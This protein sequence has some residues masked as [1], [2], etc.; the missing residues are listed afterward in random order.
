MATKVVFLVIDGY[1]QV[2]AAK[3]RILTIVFYFDF[4]NCIVRTDFLFVNFFFSMMSSGAKMDERERYKRA[5][6]ELLLLAHGWSI[7]S[8]SRGAAH[9]LIENAL[10]L[11]GPLK[12]MRKG[13]WIDATSCELIRREN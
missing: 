6:Q 11:E 12:V 7:F 8:D 2:T 5:L 3:I 1:N 10:N 13:K 9:S 4:H